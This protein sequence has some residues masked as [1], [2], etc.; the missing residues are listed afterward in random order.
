MIYYTLVEKFNSESGNL[1]DKYKAKN[2]LHDLLE[3]ISL[4]SS[5]CPAAELDGENEVL[6]DP[7]FQHGDAELYMD[8]KKSVVDIHGELNANDWNSIA[9][10]FN[11]KG[12]GS[13]PSKDF[14]FVGYDLLDI[15]TRT[16]TLVNCGRLETA[17]SS[18]DL[19]SSGLIDDLEKSI[20]VQDKIKNYCPDL[21][22]NNT[23]IVAIWVKKT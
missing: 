21:S 17:F 15:A 7:N 13:S 2:G 6:Q 3:I 8:L 4:D 11:P 19:N 23:T 5:L 20:L 14:K 12:E 9:V 1:W 10:E 16:S 22:H 18:E